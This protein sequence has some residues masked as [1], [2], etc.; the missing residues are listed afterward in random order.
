MVILKK[1]CWVFT[2]LTVDNGQKMRFYLISQHI[3]AL[4]QGSVGVA[5]DNEIIYNSWGG[6]LWYVEGSTP[7]EYVVHQ[8][9]I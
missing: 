6:G 8:S 9:C 5:L 2:Y 3:F 4:V 7:T 1:K